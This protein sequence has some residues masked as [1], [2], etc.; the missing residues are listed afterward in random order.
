MRD[1]LTHD[2]KYKLPPH[3]PVP[4]LLANPRHRIKVMFAPMFALVK[5]LTTNARKCTKIGAL[6]LKKYI[7]C[8][9]Y[10]IE[11]YQ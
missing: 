2:G 1:H 8:Y 11:T 6:R 10:Q 7:G 4:T 5:G 3:I 9:I